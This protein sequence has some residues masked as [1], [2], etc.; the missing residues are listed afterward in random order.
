MDKLA[1][2]RWDKLQKEG[3][4]VQQK[5][6]GEPWPLYIGDRKV[7]KDFLAEIHEQVS[8]SKA[9]QYWNPLMM[10]SYWQRQTH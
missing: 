4:Q 10:W 9:R 6:D 5:I 2:E 3:P 1:K 8:G 7:S